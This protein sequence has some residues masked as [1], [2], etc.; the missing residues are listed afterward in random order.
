MEV[1]LGGGLGQDAAEG[2]VGGIRFDAKG[3][4]RLEVLEDGGRCEGPLQLPESC[5]CLFR[6]GK[7]DSLATESSEGGS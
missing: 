5:T 4:F 3:E 1:A 6:P 7:L 2:E